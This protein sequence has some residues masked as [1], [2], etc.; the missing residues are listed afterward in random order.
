MSRFGRQASSRYW[1]FKLSPNDGSDLKNLV[2]TPESA[3]RSSCIRSSGGMPC[4]SGKVAAN[5]L[6]RK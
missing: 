5:M 4:L 6:L 3:L 2:R 1:S